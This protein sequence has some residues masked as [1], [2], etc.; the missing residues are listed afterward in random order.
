MQARCSSVLV[1]PLQAELQSDRQ[2]MVLHDSSAAPLPS[3]PP[4]G[5]HDFIV[6]HEVKELGS[7]TLVCSSMYVAQD[8][9]RRMQP[10]VWSAA[11]LSASQSKLPSVP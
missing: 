9:S 6:R 1:M 7:H 11:V 3:L 2:N 10:Q 8:G 5:R 4:G